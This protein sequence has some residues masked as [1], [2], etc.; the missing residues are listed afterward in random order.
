MSAICLVRYLLCFICPLIAAKPTPINTLPI[1]AVCIVP[2]SDLMSKNLD[3]QPGKSMEELYQAMPE[4]PSTDESVLFCRITQLLYNEQVTILD[5]QDDQVLVETEFW[6]FKPS[7][8]GKKQIKNNCFWMLQKDVCPLSKLPKEYTNSLPSTLGTHI[9]IPN[10]YKEHKNSLP[11]SLAAPTKA[12]LLAYQNAR[13]N[14]KQPHTRA[15]KALNTKSTQLI[16]GLKNSWKCPET[17]D[18]FS[19][20]TRFVVAEPIHDK[21]QYTVSIFN[22][23]TNQMVSSSIPTK[24][25]VIEKKR[26]EQE[27]R[28][29]LVE[30]LENWAHTTPPM[31]Y[32]LGGASTGDTNDQAMRPH[33]GLDCSGLVRRACRLVGIPVTATNSLSLTDFFK[34]LAAHTMPQKGDLLYWNGHIIFITNTKKHLLIEARGKNQG[35]GHVH[36]TH[37]SKQLQNMRTTH[38]LV[39]V[40]S[41]NRPVNR[42]NKKGAIH[43]QIQ[44]IILLKLI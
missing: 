8:S 29:L 21:K 18:L 1:P 22:P 17:E 34:P 13:S 12:Q 41:Q 16:V 5:T 44:K 39:K 24:L 30:I 15:P 42:L 35:Y 25:C 3:P 19:A 4:T 23:R 2:V 14:N 31:P 28:K 7:P 38:D 40:Y 33:R 26:T 11:G 43:K 36:E 20:G 37:F 10:L 32:I 6:H 27:Q 9:H